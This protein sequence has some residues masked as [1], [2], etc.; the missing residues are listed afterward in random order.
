M[1]VRAIALVLGVSLLCDS[2]ALAAEPGIAV[3]KLPAVTES[4]PVA[5]DVRLGGD[6]K[7]CI[8][9]SRTAGLRPTPVRLR[10]QSRFWTLSAP[11]YSIRGY[12]G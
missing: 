1:T 2:A 8:R 10:G 12:F 3:Q 9:D 6:D 5:T 7:M 4:I 11:F